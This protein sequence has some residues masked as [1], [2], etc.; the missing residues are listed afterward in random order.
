[1]LDTLK[2]RWQ[3]LTGALAR[4]PLSLF[5]LTS[6]VSVGFVFLY[7]GWTKVDQD[8]NITPFAILLFKQ[9]YKVPLLPPETA[10]LLATYVELTVPWLLVVGLCSRLAALPLLGMV[11]VIQTFVYPEAW[12]DHLLWATALGLVVANGP[13]VFSL[14]Y[15]IGRFFGW[16]APFAAALA[17]APATPVPPP[18][19]TAAAMRPPSAP[20]A[21]AAAADA[22]LGAGGGQ[23]ADNR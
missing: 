13:G 2:T 17:A 18:A 6:R 7:S 14:D 3:E 12:R 1:M 4:V 10:A 19:A 22:P 5:L 15:L 20:V 21:P 23:P 9:E 8:Y 11:V 16:S